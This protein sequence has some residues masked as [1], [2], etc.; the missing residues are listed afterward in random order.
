MS[1][2]RKPRKS[3][4][5]EKP[6]E[7]LGS[8]NLF[9]KSTAQVIVA[10]LYDGLLY[11][12]SNTDEMPSYQELRDCS[13][14]PLVKLALDL[15]TG[16]LEGVPWRYELNPNLPPE[17][18]QKYKG[19]CQWVE[20]NVNR[21]RNSILTQGIRNMLI[22]GY[23]PF[24]IIYTYNTKNGLYE[25]KRLKPLLHEYTWILVDRD[26]EFCGFEQRMPHTKPRI[27][28]KQDE[29]F[30]MSLD[31]VG[32]NWYG[33][34]VLESTIPLWK[35]W[36]N[37]NHQVD[38]FFN[39]CVGSRTALY[40][41]VGRSVVGTDGE[42]KPVEMDNADIARQSIAAMDQNFGIALP[43]GTS[44]VVDQ[45]GSGERAWQVDTYSD[46]PGN[47]SVFIERQKQIEEL[48]VNSVGFPV[49]IFQEGRAS[50]SRAELESF[51]DISATIMESRNH[52]LATALQ[53]QI[54]NPLTLNNFGIDDLVQIQVGNVKQS[55]LFMSRHPTL[56]PNQNQ[57]QREQLLDEYYDGQPGGES[58]PEG[59]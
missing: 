10:P 38:R 55:K 35:Q 42:G 56:D 44:R 43:Q 54:V 40:Y 37:I 41:P 24:E 13:K 15:L 51:T 45:A 22:Y 23:S 57:D 33:T 11:R 2:A 31:V 5:V 49:R 28:L 39:R 16:E 20:T 26:G 4:T 17:L 29:S 18:I 30:I 36:C 47:V 1:P 12:Y 59:E 7:T 21:I 48:L 6:V 8:P 58:P 3:L 14:H 50:G 32:Q 9:D 46:T 19:V 34:S 25:I 53:E 27:R 52:I